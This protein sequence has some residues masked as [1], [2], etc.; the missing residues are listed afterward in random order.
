MCLWGWRHRSVLQLHP[1][2]FRHCHAD[3]ASPSSL[4]V[5]EELRD[6]GGC[7]FNE[8]LHS[9]S[10]YG[11]WNNASVSCLFVRPQTHFLPPFFHIWRMKP[12]QVPW[13]QIS[14]GTLAFLIILNPPCQ[15]FPLQ[16]SNWPQTAYPSWN[17]SDHSRARCGVFFSVLIIVDA[18][19]SLWSFLHSLSH[20]TECVAFLLFCRDSS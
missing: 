13:C 1:A 2:A 11:N 17:I 14:A 4:V 7:I 3:E 19:V 8:T 12:R 16:K 9:T 18:G 6:S 20:P 10:C 5:T 15:P